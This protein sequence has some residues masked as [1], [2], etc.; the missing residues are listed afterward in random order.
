MGGSDYRSAKVFDDAARQVTAHA[1]VQPAR[2]T[3]VSVRKR[4]VHTPLGQSPMAVFVPDV[5]STVVP[6]ENGPS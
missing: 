5:C 6:V 1:M 2:V 3:E 4:N